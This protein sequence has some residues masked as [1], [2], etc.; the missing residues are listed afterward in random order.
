[1]PKIEK[2]SVLCLR[3]N[4]STVFDHL[5]SNTRYLCIKKCIK[6][7]IRSGSPEHS[8]NDANTN[9]KNAMF[10]LTPYSITITPLSYVGVVNTAG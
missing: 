7:S 5:S 9:T 8:Q 2:P 3:G 10:C 4:C 6:A 1:M